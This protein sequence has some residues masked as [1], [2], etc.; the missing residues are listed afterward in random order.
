M[1][2]ICPSKKPV[3]LHRSCVT[4]CFLL[5]LA[6]AAPAQSPH[7]GFSGEL[8][9]SQEDILQAVTDI[10]GDGIV[11]GTYVF[12]KEKTLT[13]AVQAESAPYFPPWEGDGKVYYKICRNVIAPRHFQESEDQGT[14][15]VRYVLRQVAAG[16]AR[17]LIA[18]VYFETVRRRTH[19]S[20]GTV[21]TEEFKAIQ[22][23][24]QSMQAAAQEAAEAQRH[25]EGVELAR[26]SI[27]RQR[28][29]E[30]A[31]LAAAQSSVQDLQQQVSALRHELVRRV[32]EPGADLKA[33]PFRSAA[34]VVSLT[35]YSEV[36]VVIVTPRWLGVETSEGQRGWIPQDKLEL[37]P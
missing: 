36:V 20:D 17:L 2:S 28:E 1:I 32:K 37:L 13:G 3:R 22:A 7:P 18:A 24:L 15:A 23:D 35:A 6:A 12:E 34:N 30:S 14:I 10:V 25:R 4:L 31:R 5:T 21:E 8:A 9:G 11:H 26:Q 27:L 16:R 29:D 33:A 19:V